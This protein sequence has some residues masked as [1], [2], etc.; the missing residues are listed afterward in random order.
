MKRIKL[1][2]LA[3]LYA[4]LLIL[5]PGSSLTTEKTYTNSLGLEFTLIPAGSFT[6]GADK[7]FENALYGETPQHRVSISQPFYLGTYE[8][9]QAQ[10]TAVMGSNPSRFEGQSNPV[11][12]VSWDDAQAFIKRLNQQEGHSRY[13]LPTEAEWEYAARAG[14]T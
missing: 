7:N 4:C 10:W 12:Q 5:T 6:M 13:R 3:A 11:E 1:W 9:T 14:T 8:V 2:S